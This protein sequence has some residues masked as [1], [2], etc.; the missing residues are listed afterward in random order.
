[1]GGFKALKTHIGSL[2]ITF[3][4]SNRFVPVR[5]VVDPMNAGSEVGVQPG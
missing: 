2:I 3:I 5:A 4:F 1:M